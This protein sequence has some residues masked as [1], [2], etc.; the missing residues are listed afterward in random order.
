MTRQLLYETMQLS[1][2]RFVQPGHDRPDLGRVLSKHSGHQLPTG[3]RECKEFGPL[4]QRGGIAT[5]EEGCLHEEGRSE[6]MPRSAH[7]PEATV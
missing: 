1:L 2:L 5:S 7:A 3:G 6:A 4:I